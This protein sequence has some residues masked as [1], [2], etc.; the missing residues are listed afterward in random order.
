MRQF[1]CLRY[2]PLFFLAVSSGG[3]ADDDIGRLPLWEIGIGGAF[4][5]LPQ[6]IGSDQRTETVLPIPYFVYRGEAIKISRDAFQ[7]RLFERSDLVVDLS[8]DFSLPVDSDENRAREDMPDIDFILEVGPALRWNFY[9]NTPAHRKISIEVPLRAVLQ[10]NLRYLSHEGWRINPRLRYQEH[11]DA[12]FFSLWGGWYWNDA[13]YNRLYY[14][15]EQ[16]FASAD[17][18]NYETSGGFGGWALSSSLTYR[19]NDWWVGGFIRWHDVRQA[20]FSGSPLV[21]D[22]TNLGFGIA[23]AWIWKS[24][25]KGVSRWN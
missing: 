25:D 1:A 23:A 17:R 2:L 19:R 10:S 3:Y 20:T 12:W 22:P 9:N 4:L 8:A 15:V 6:Y 5:N 18:E 11:F 14:G 21:V 16:Q 24:S 13:R 7:T